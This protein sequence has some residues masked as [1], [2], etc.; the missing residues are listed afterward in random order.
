M[1]YVLVKNE[2]EQNSL[3]V[4]KFSIYFLILTNKTA[5]IYTNT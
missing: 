3:N 2:D 4:K 1:Y 5:L